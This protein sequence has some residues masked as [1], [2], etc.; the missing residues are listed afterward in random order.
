MIKLIGTC[1]IGMLTLSVW[2]Q[3]NSYEVNQLDSLQYIEKR[4]V[5]FFIHTDWCSICHGMENQ[6]INDSIVSA[7]LNTHFYYVPFNAESEE[8]VYFKG[9]K[10]T[11]Q[12]NGVGNGKHKL[13]MLL[14]DKEGEIAFPSTVI[15]MNNDV[16]YK[17]NSYITE[18]DLMAVLIAI[19][20]RA[21]GSLIK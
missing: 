14:A 6:V 5:V 13:A 2:A 9:K 21:I 3:P 11:Y 12:N 16:I 19:K 18:K 1:L 8:A 7:E 10:Y 17:N 20:D 4:P 15:L